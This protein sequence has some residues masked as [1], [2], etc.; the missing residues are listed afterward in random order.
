MAKHSEGTEKGKFCAVRK[1][2][3]QKC[4]DG[5]EYT[6][7]IKD[8]E[9]KW[10][11]SWGVGTFQDLKFV[12]GR[13][14]KSHGQFEAH[15][16][17]CVASVTEHLCGGGGD[18]PILPI[19][20]NT[21]WCINHENNMLTMPLWGHTVKYYCDL[22]TENIAASVRARSREVDLPPPFANTP[23]HNYDHNSKKGYKKNHVDKAMIKVAKRVQKKADED[24]KAAVEDL[25][26]T[27]DNLSKTFKGML[28][29][30]GSQNGGTH[31][32]WKDG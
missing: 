26:A 4:K 2:P 1:S 9:K 24:H 8:S 14:K 16:L 21:E 32:S 13:K 15:H 12:R 7:C 25:K 23:Q 5:N 3:R 29:T 20:E 10:D 19:L 31:K 11:A 18:S 17:L 27:L 30:L 22:E 6:K 28:Q